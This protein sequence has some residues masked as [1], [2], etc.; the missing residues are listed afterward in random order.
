MHKNELVPKNWIRRL[1]VQVPSLTP[2]GTFGLAPVCRVYPL[3]WVL[4]FFYKSFF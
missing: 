1:G 4:T 3:L 2:M